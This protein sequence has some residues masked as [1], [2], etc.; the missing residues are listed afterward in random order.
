MLGALLLNRPVRGRKQAKNGIRDGCYIMV[1]G[2]LI[3]T[4]DRPTAE[5]VKK[6]V[7]LARLRLPKAEKKKAERLIAKFRKTERQKDA[8]LGFRCA[9]ADVLAYQ[10]L[11]ALLRKRMEEDEELALLMVLMGIE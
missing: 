9:Q 8:E 6:V 7:R 4:R 2:T 1:A 3:D 10:G 11:L 5:A